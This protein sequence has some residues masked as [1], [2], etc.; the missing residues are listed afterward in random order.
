M[1]LIPG[2]VSPCQLRFLLGREAGLLGGRLESLGG[3]WVLRGAC[4]LLAFRKEA[5]K[6][7]GEA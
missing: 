1:Q 7:E 3:V 6:K 2:P 4:R 5:G